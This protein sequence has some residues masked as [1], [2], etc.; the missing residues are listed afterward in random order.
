MLP[1]IEALVDK[2]KS[3]EAIDPDTK[4]KATLYLEIE[5]RDHED[6]IY[7][8]LGC[9]EEGNVYTRDIIDGD[10]IS[11]K[12]EGL[13][14]CHRITHL[15]PNTPW[16]IEDKAA[17]PEG[18]FRRC[19]PFRNFPMYMPSHGTFLVRYRGHAKDGLT[20]LEVYRTKEHE[21]LEEADLKDGLVRVDKWLEDEPDPEADIIIE[22]AEQ[23]VCRKRDYDSWLRVY[24]ELKEERQ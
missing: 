18:K 5:F 17:S 23:M 7:S 6:L 1:H 9:D 2:S 3:I 19:G 12:I 11:E 15:P 24:N 14:L 22:Q 10:P 21:D 16:N 8:Y 20:F 4:K 13:P